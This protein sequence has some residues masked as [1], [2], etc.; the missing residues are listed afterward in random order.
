MNVELNLEIEREVAPEFNQDLLSGLV[1]TQ[2]GTFKDDVDKYIYCASPSFPEGFEF[3]RSVRCSPQ[4]AFRVMSGQLSKNDKVTPVDISPSDVRLYRYE[5]TFEGVPLHPRYL[6]LPVPE[7]GDILRLSGKRFALS[8][9]LADPGFSV[10]RDEV[11][12]RMTRAPVSFRREICSVRKYDKQTSPVGSN[13]FYS[14]S[15]CSLI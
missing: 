13:D 15:N 9:V 10:T 4:E 14:S 1:Y 12:F 3:K 6:N 8:A 11:F 2:A 7:E 5:F